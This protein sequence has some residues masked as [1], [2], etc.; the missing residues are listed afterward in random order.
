MN[1]GTAH[2]LF[3]ANPMADNHSDKIKVCLSRAADLRGQAVTAADTVSKD[4]LRGLESQWLA[5]AESYKL[6]E[7]SERYLKG[8]RARRSAAHE[9]I[10]SARRKVEPTT[11]ASGE[12][13]APAGNAPLADLLGILVRTAIEYTHGN[14]RA[15]FYL[16]DGERKTLH[17]VTG[18]PDDYAK[19]VDGFAIGPESL[20]CGL[21][22]SM[23]RP[24]I[25]P[26]VIA[27]PRWRPWLW[28]PRQ[29]DYRACWSFPIEAAGGRMLGSFAMY[30]KE[31]TEAT[32]HELDLAAALTRAASTVIARR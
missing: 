4:E 24:V 25:T 23:Q 29:F 20:A 7:Q 26:D 21:C 19:F 27:E 30:Y 31:P 32:S 28:L 6:V 2:S 22:V 13:S 10:V 16:A 9:R 15:A 17:H 3:V 5:I 18:M 12:V 14:A 1:Q 11:D 8:L